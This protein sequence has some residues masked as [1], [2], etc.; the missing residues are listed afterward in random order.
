MQKTMLFVHGI[1]VRGEAYFRSLDLVARKAKQFLPGV[2]VEGCQWGDP[3]GARLNRNGASIPG[4]EGNGDAKPALEDAAR[5]LWYLLSQD[6]LLEL[7]VL[8]QQRVIGEKPGVWIWQQCPA[9]ATDQDMLKLL[10]DYGVD[11]AWPDF[12]AEICADKIWD[13]VVTSVTE[14]RAAASSKVARAVTAAFQIHLRKSGLP[15]LTGT[16]RDLLR[17][18][19]V[20]PF[21]GPAMGV[22]DWFL[23]R[24]IHSAGYYAGNRRGRVTDAT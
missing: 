1:N 9:V 12:V 22:G 13:K 14:G 15:G 2:Q 24:F 19:L 6:P 5:A 3:F 17:D 21:G 4:Y 11:K 20:R 18:Q 7:R 16:Q 23:E 10:A 8:P